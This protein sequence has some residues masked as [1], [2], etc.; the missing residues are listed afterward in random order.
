MAE[1]AD[2]LASEF[3]GEVNDKYYPQVMEG[4]DLMEGGDLSQGLEIIARPL[5]TIK[6]VSGFMSGFEDASTF[7]HNVESFLKK[8]QSG[9]MEA[10]PSM[11][12]LAIE[13]VNTVFGVL[14]AL[15]QGQ[16]FGDTDAEEIL[17][18]INEAKGERE[19]PSDQ[20]E[21]EVS[22]EMVGDRIVVRPGARRLHLSGQ[23]KK[24]METLRALP[25]GSNVLVDL[26]AV[27]SI[28]TSTL[29]E[30]ESLSHVLHIR[31]A[32]LSPACKEIVFG[33]RFD[34]RLA[35]DGGSADAGAE[36]SQT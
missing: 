26:S 29:E 21:D 9:D 32:G 5:H 10:T 7:T 22:L 28:G 23:R 27:E 6:G 2:A 34:R 3:M 1:N 14:E 30:V 4:L 35:V 11:V 25:E 19:R 24:L 16:G 33:W 20:T 31:L 12:G 17:A 36:D 15:Y 8:L 13:A 18:R